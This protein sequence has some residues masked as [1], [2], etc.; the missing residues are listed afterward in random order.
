[1]VG[2]TKALEM[3]YDLIAPFGV[4][5]SVGVHNHHVP[6]TLTGGALYDKNVALLFGRCPVRALME[7]AADLLHRRVKI[8]GEVESECGEA[9]LVERVVPIGEAR[10][11]YEKFESGVWGKV[12][13]DPW[14]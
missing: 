4:I 3:S 6:L 11:A 10:E 12:L 14:K 1:V 2:N 8:F 7:L 9:A 5:A 13:F